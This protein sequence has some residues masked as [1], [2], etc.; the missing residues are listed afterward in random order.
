MLY[1]EAL[2]TKEIGNLFFIVYGSNFETITSLVGLFRSTEPNEKDT[3]EI[4]RKCPQLCSSLGQ[5]KV[6]ILEVVV[7]L[8]PGRYDIIDFQFSLSLVDQTYFLLPKST[9]V[10]LEEEAFTSRF[11]G[12]KKY[13][14][15]NYGHGNVLWPSF[16]EIK[17]TV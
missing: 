6:K 17:H 13:V 10:R 3:Q 1:W 16:L 15:H 11:D 9:Q 5:G 12:K 7:G 8:R 14:I 4:L 2:H